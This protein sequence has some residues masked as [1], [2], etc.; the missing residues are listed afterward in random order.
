MRDWQGL[1]QEQS[2]EFIKSVASDDDLVLFE[3]SLCEVY[4][5]PLSFYEGYSLYR[6]VNKYMLPNLILDYLSNGEDHHYLDGSDQAF[7][8]LNT[9]RAL[10]LGLSNA[11]DYLDL[12]IS[13]VYERGHSLAFL[14]DPEEARK[15]STV[16]FDESAQEYTISTPLV[17]HDNTVQ[18]KAVVNQNGAI[19][20]STPVK[21]SFLH[22]LKP[23]TDI[24][25]RHTN[26]EQITEQSIAILS[27][28]EAGQNLLKL[29]DEHSV[30]IRVLSS[31][32]Y[33]GVITNDLV[34][35]L[36]IPAA[37]QNA[38]FFQA[39]VL[40]YALRD[41]QQ[42]AGGY[43]HPHPSIDKDEYLTANYGKNLDMIS[44]MCEIVAEFEDANAPGALMALKRMGL[45]IVF[46]AYKEGLQGDAL[47]E[48]YIKA[49]EKD[50]TIMR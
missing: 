27:E 4:T 46:D 6:I 40:T 17:Y 35:Y 33:H 31:P 13:Y 12:Y 10:S 39:L 28:S 14:G 32:N 8:N 5:L 7:H 34:I 18:G 36:V 21:A 30:E 44:K 1:D 2:I 15:Q 29:K 43:L 26:E 38:K 47:M 11:L 9:K 25:Y 3:P 24:P 49:L 20:L 23:H 50:G 41:V 48:V 42:I 19:T 45:G 22:E 16:A 37:E